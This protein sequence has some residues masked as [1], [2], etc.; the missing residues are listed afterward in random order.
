[1]KVLHGGVEA[2]VMAESAGRP[3]PMMGWLADGLPISLLV[4]LFLG[5]RLD[6]AEVM[7]REGV[8]AGKD[9]MSRWPHPAA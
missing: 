5:D 3:N 4:D 6:S 7:R 1:M 8:V 2:L 9:A